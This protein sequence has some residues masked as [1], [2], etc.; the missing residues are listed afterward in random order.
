MMSEHDKPWWLVE[1]C[2]P[3]MAWDGETETAWTFEG[4]QS[5]LTRRPVGVAACEVLTFF[6]WHM[7]AEEILEVCRHIQD[8]TLIQ[9]TY[10]NWGE[11]MAV[12]RDA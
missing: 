1:G 3:I 5:E 7:T 10:E 9:G 8:G 12:H 6:G 4:E 2:R 11:F